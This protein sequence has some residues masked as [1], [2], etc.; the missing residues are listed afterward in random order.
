MEPT[1]K[2]DRR[3]QLILVLL[4]VLA[5]VRAGWILLEPRF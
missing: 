3:I 4:A 1:N 5:L 2:L